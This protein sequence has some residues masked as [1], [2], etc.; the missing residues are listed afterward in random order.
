MEDGMRT[1]SLVI[2]LVSPYTNVWHVRLSPESGQ[3]ISIELPCHTLE[4][5][6]VLARAL[7]D[8]QVNCYPWKG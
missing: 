7:S 6:K 1:K 5:A 2:T 4:H 3:G 8:T